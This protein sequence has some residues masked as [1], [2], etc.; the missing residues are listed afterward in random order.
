MTPDR[1]D[2]A[3]WAGTLASIGAA[4]LVAGGLR[5]AI[6]GEMLR[7]SEILLAA[8]GILLLGGIV[9]GF[10]RIVAFFSKRSSQLGTNTT[11]LTLAVIAILG[12]VNFLGHQHHKRFDLTAEKLF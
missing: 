3:S 5:Y 7:T 11:I 9:L 4:C 6:Q 12:F 1:Q 2:R 8:G 10:G